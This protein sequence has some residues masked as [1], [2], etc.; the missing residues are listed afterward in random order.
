[1]AKIGRCPDCGALIAYRFTIHE[2]KSILEKKDSELAKL[3]ATK[4]AAA[5]IVDR[6]RAELIEA[7]GK[8]REAE[9]AITA[10]WRA[11]GARG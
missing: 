8:L 2:C 7:D 11:K 5:L 4:K 9:R 1:M 6:K 10:Y 3:M